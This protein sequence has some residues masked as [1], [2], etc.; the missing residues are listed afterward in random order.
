[1]NFELH[2]VILIKNF[3]K[4]A[5]ITLDW[6]FLQLSKRRVLNDYI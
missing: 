6:L 5:D 4:I 1:M 2:E 3:S